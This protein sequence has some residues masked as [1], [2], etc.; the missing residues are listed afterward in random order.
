MKR[1]L[2]TIAF[3]L[4]TPCLVFAQQKY[5]PLIEIPG[6][7]D[8]NAANQGFG[9]YVNFL[10]AASIG[11]AAFLAVIKIII[12]G[13][14]YMTT[15][16]VNSKSNAKG[17]ITGALLGLLLILGA[18]MILNIINPRLVNP[19]VNFQPIPEPPKTAAAP[20]SV[21][22]V[23]G[24]TQRP[25]QAAKELAAA[26]EVCVKTTQGIGKSGK[27]VVVTSDTSGCPSTD[28]QRIQTAFATYCAAKGGQPG[29]SGNNVS[30]CA[31]PI[32]SSTVKQP[33]TTVQTIGTV[34]Q[35]KTTKTLDANSYS[36][37]TMQVK[38]DAAVSAC[39][40]HTQAVATTNQQTWTVSCAIPGVITYPT[41]GGTGLFSYQADCKKQ[42]GTFQQTSNSCIIK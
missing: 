9:A 21:A 14:K 25:G 33:Q 29:S 4:L 6:V 8:A 38:L 11:I 35:A 1:T 27:T 40:A 30:S 31:F 15:D 36:G 41:T 37:R 22:A 10:Y 20:A 42:G 13:V 18:Y 3:V 34:A 26:S 7:T 28:V 17:E 24:E 39:E 16:V 19:S 5:S 12:S 32:T 23:G 2:L